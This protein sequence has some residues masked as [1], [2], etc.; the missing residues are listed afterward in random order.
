MFG[1]LGPLRRVEQ[2]F[3]PHLLERREP[4]LIALDHRVE[5]I[6]AL[7]RGE[8]RLVAEQEEE[9]LGLEIAG[10]E[11]GDRAGQGETGPHRLEALPVLDPD[12]DATA[13]L[14]GVGAAL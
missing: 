1:A 12:L 14:A 9:V 2:V 6:A 4:L 10:I 13:G 11:P 5:R 3:L 8:G 7:E